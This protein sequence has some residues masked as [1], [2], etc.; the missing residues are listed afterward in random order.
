MPIPVL[1]PLNTVAYDEPHDGDQIKFYRCR[2][3]FTVA[4]HQ[5]GID[6]LSIG[7]RA[8]SLFVSRYQGHRAFTFVRLFNR[9]VSIIFICL[10]V[11][12]LL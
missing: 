5:E 10:C 8:L 9:Y 6:Q 1:L 7:L 11:W 4:F 3:I 12:F 2:F